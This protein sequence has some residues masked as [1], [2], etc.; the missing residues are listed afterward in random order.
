MNVIMD[1]IDELKQMQN[2]PRFYLSNYFD[3]LKNEID[4]KYAVEQ[5]EQAKYLEIIKNIE[6]FEQDAYKNSKS[7]NTFDKE[8]KLIEDKLNDSNLNEI[9]Q[10]IDELKY[11]IEKILFSNKS[12]FFYDLVYNDYS[13]LIIINDEYIRK[14][15]CVE[16]YYML[17]LLTKNKLNGWISNNIIER[18]PNKDSINVLNIYINK[19]EDIKY[20]KNILFINV[21]HENTF[22]GLSNLKKID[23]S[24]NQIKAIHPNLFN[25]L[26]NLEIINISYN[27]IEVIHE[28]T[29][30]GLTSLKEID[31]SCNQIKEIHPNT[32]NEL[33]NLEIIN[34]RRNKIEIIHENTF[35]GLSNLNLKE[36]YLDDKIKGF[37]PKLFNRLVR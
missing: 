7:F 11:K 17:K 27:Q 31:F 30:N 10:L 4:I 18:T 23:F 19:E 34:F 1:Q 20:S 12:I 35:N 37:H 2:F 8:I 13:F 29:F 26:A 15:N 24:Y 32:F 28:N 9:T 6:L 33:T 22:N 36:V 3:E 16:Y 5:D 14:N 21:I 25:G